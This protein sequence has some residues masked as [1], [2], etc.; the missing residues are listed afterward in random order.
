VTNGKDGRFFPTKTAAIEHVRSLKA[1]GIR[2]ID[3]GCM[4][5][6]LLHHPNAFDDLETAFNPSANA[7]YDARFLNK[8]FGAHKSWSEAI[9]RYRSSTAKFHRPYH[10]KVEAA[11]KITRLGPAEPHRQSVI[12]R[13]LAKR[14]RHAKPNWQ[15]RIRN[16]LSTPWRLGRRRRCMAWYSPVTRKRRHDERACRRPS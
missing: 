16:T 9:R 1:I 11:L 13:H 4:Q 8:L 3:V 6:N 14:V 10:A 12:A 5:I 15:R 2:N 7:T